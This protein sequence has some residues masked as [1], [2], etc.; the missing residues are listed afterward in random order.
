MVV[1]MTGSVTAGKGGSGTVHA[2]LCDDPHAT[3]ATLT[4][5]N[6]QTRAGLRLTRVVPFPC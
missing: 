4:P 3:R 6:P 1:N 5:S 2:M